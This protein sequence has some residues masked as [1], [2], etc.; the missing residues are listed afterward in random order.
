MISVC[1]IVKRTLLVDDVNASALCADFD[2]F[3]IISSL[4]CC[5]QLIVDRHGAFNCGLSMESKSVESYRE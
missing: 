3:D 4:S 5:L 2:V 1:G